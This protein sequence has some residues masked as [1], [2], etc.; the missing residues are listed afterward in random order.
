MEIIDNINHL[1]GENLKRTIKP[2]AKLKIAASCFSIYAFAA[3]K[4]ELERVESL[5]FIFTAPT[6][7]PHE[8]TDKIKKEQREF[9]IPKAGRE[10]SFYVSEFEIQL[11]NKLTQRA[12]AK[13]CADWM[14]RKATFKSNHSKAPMQQ[15]GLCRE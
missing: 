4:R 11:K 15:F 12:I 10:R 1:L 9:H 6:F 14:R 13:E 5:E 3:L 8:V 2:N 7:V